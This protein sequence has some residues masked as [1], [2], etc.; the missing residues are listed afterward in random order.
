MAVQQGYGKMA[1]TDAL[2][3]AYDTGDAVNSYKGEPVTNLW[4]SVLNTQSLRTHTKHYWNGKKW[5]EDATYT[6][7][8]VE[9]PRGVY[10]GI[11]FKH[12][13]GAFNSSWSGN[14]Y[15]YM[16]RDI[17]CT[18]GATMTQSAWIYL[19]EDCNLDSVPSVIEQEAGGESTVA[20]YPA[21]YNLSN[22]GT[23]QV[24]AKKATSDGQVR[25]IPLYPSKNG[26]TNGTFTGFLMWGLPQ[27]T[28][29]DHVVQPIQPGATRSA[30]QG[31]L[32]LTGNST[33]DLSNVS[34]T[35]DAQVDLDGTS[36]YIDLGSDVTISP[37]NQGWTAE[38]VFNTDSASTLQHFNS[39]E[40]DDFNANWLAL[41]SSKL[42]VWDHGQG[43]WRY[44]NTQFS[45]DTWYHIAFVQESGTSMQFYVNGV[46]EGGD[47]TSFSWSSNYS[48]LKTRYIGR[49]EYNGGYGRYF[50]GELPV[51]KLY[52]RALTAAEVK[53]NF[54]NYKTR[55]NIA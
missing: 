15:G 33:I 25:F 10:L 53:R 41:L 7:P 42:A 27:V 22:K 31:L 30:T 34:F 4:D 1:G 37:N 55:F 49:Y 14:S 40:A 35:S 24:T 47:H 3:F 17:A 5:T 8:G 52:N 20:G 11:V 43:T 39:A 13:S 6:H 21:S 28:Y 36:D 26:T 9:G 48:A 44:G 18:S 38:Y 23:W 29:G 45:S 46:A 2:V 32:D 16:L 19:S 54:N 12:V 51:T 50:N